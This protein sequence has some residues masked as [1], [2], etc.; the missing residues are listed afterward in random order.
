MELDR[1]PL[2]IVHNRFTDL[3]H[4]STA[5]TMRL[6]TLIALC[7]LLA[8]DTQS[9][10]DSSHSATI[11]ATQ[12]IAECAEALGGA[13]RL[14]NLRAF[15]TTASWDGEDPVVTEVQRPNMFKTL[16][17]AVLVFDGARAAML[18]GPEENGE[19]GGPELLGAEVWKDFEID[20][21]F[22]FPAF[23][24]YRTEYLGLDTLDGTPVHQLLVALPLETRM[25]YLIDANTHLPLAARTAVTIDG[26]DYTPERVYL[27]FREV[28]GILFP[29]RFRQGWTPETAQTGVLESAEVN[30]AFAEDHFEIP[31]ALLEKR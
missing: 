13:E 8:C 19:A 4:Y 30:V 5:R 16:G 23:F 22:N 1:V 20:F 3:V 14:D 10:G 27:E 26:T 28:E 7:C 18:Q 31:A 12:I 24:D 9:A 2:C 11:T 25:T 21:A 29:S 6:V 15:R 17:R